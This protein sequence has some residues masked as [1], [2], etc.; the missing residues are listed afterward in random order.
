MKRYS[1][2]SIIFLLSLFLAACT[3]NEVELQPREEY[4][5]EIQARLDD[6]T[7]QIKDLKVDVELG[8]GE[9]ID[10]TDL[11]QTIAELQVQADAAAKELE[12]LS[13]A[14]ADAWED[15]KPGLERA[16]NELEQAYE[17]A[18]TNFEES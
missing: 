5:A 18:R 12:A 14:S 13:V 7:Q 2:L 3:T 9:E 8:N 16:L 11:N 10:T 4:Q 17:K 15:F 1:F 6:L